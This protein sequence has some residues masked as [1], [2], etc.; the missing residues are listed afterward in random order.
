MNTHSVRNFS[1]LLLAGVF[2]LAIALTLIDGRTLH[3]QAPAPVTL[4]VITRAY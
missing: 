1:R 4:T 2:L 3:A